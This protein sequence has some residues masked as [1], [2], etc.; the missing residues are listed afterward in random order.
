VEFETDT[1]NFVVYLNPDRSHLL[2]SYRHVEPCPRCAG[3]NSTATIE[4]PQV[5]RDSTDRP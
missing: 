3:E 5:E 1:P 2:R 4:L